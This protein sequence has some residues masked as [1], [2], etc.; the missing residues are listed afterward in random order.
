MPPKVSRRG[1]A[2]ASG[3]DSLLQSRSTSSSCVSGAP[4]V[5]VVHFAQ[6][7]LLSPFHFDCRRTGPL[8][9]P[10]RIRGGTSMP[11]RYSAMHAFRIWTTPFCR[12]TNQ[13]APSEHTLREKRA[14]LASINFSRTPGEFRI[15]IGVRVWLFTLPREKHSPH[16]P[17][18]LHPVAVL[19]EEIFQ[20]VS[21]CGLETLGNIWLRDCY[22]GFSRWKHCGST[23]QYT[24]VPCVRTLFL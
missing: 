5:T 14:T 17:F 23:T 9:N 18:E 12:G 7:N 24:S 6:L 4:H 11:A 15:A 2:T 8:V 1:S 3:P 13:L 21:K 19:D 22:H 16:A 20:C 10:F